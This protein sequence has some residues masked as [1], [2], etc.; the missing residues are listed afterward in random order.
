MNGPAQAAAA[1]WDDLVE[2][3]AALAAGHITSV[4]LTR[5]TLARIEQLNPVL[6]CYL[7]VDAAGA[8]EAAAAA[9]ARRL[10]GR[11]LGP[12]DGLA[13]AVKD[14]IDVAGMPTTAGMATRRGRIAVADAFTVAGLRAAGA[15]ILGKLNMHEGALGATNRNPHYGDCHNPHRLGYTPGGSSGG[16]ACAVAAG[17]AAAALGSDTMGSVRIP[18]SYCGVSGHKPSRGLVSTGGSVACSYRLDTIG[19]LARSARDL[20]LLMDVLAQFDPACP[21][22]R[23]SWPAAGPAPQTLLAPSD[24]AALGVDAALAACFERQLEVFAGLGLRILRAPFADYDFGAARRAGLLSCEG[25]MLLE[26][27]EDRAAQPDAFSPELRAMLDFAAGKDLAS[28]TRANRT[29]DRAALRSHAW[30]DMADMV[31]LPTTPQTAFP[32]TA[33]VPANQADLT[34]IA[35][36]AGLPALSVPMPVAQGVLPAGLQLVGPHGADRTVLALGQRYQQA[37][38]HV[39]ARPAPE[40][41]QAGS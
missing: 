27:A 5:A 2:Q 26:H 3:G 15:V 10:A 8:L 19:P 9:D 24:L 35:N 13:L 1:V 37:C 12:L 31:A 29:I 38:G 23:A 7:H 33:P 20:A 6:N 16:S 39:F 36:M 34:S 25:D 4:E 18:A 28:L 30:F 11:P 21:E 22:A 32:F 17:M 40:A 14:N 41:L